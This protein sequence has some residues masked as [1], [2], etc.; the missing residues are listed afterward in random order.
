MWPYSR[1]RLHF[2]RKKTSSSSTCLSGKE[3]VETPNYFDKLPIDVLVAIL[4]KVGTID[5]LLNVQ[6]VC[7][8]WRNICLDPV[9]WRSIDIHNIGKLCNLPDFLV[10]SDDLP[11][12]VHKLTQIAIDRSCGQL[13]NI[14]LEYMGNDHLLEYITDR[15]GLVFR[16]NKLKRLRFVW[17][18]ITDEGLSK[19]TKK[20][21]SIE[22]LHIVGDIKR[23]SLEIVGLN[24]PGLKSL[25]FKKQCLIT[26]IEYTEVSGHGISFIRYEEDYDYDDGIDPN[27]VALAIS[28]T[29][30]Q[31][32]H[33]NLIGNGM[34]NEG[35]QA[36]LDSCPRLESLDLRK[37]FRVDLRADLVLDKRCSSI[38]EFYHPDDS[39][40]PNDDDFLSY[41]EADFEFPNNE[42]WQ[43]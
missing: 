40:D 6:L 13:V 33:L 1:S 11:Y 9:I 43:W 17:S 19:V 25:T 41:D 12:D 5:I 29:M 28:R 3:V 23:V 42:Y 35:L 31:L 22:E 30:P 32:Q 39:T 21:S 7:V 2:G 27:F 10:T 18:F 14:N 38:K 26:K 34:T 15:L 4:Q 37:C 8:L 24:C 16:K 36:I 20:M